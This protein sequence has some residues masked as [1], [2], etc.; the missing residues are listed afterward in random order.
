MDGTN[1]ETANE[2]TSMPTEVGGEVGGEAGGEAG[3]EVGGEIGKASSV[4]R[5]DAS[6]AE[7]EDTNRIAANF[8]PP[9][10]AK[11]ADDT[12][13]EAQLESLS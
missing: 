13:T 10:A 6:E 8:W 12:A 5:Q 7:A 11:G 3:G 9:P 2:P 1:S 4:I